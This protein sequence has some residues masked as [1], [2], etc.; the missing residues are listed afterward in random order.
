MNLNKAQYEHRLAA[1]REWG[2][3]LDVKTKA[4][5]ARRLPPGQAAQ[6]ETE[7]KAFSG[8]EGNS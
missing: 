7:V 1:L 5:Q 6:V 4:V 2:K 8:R 3:E